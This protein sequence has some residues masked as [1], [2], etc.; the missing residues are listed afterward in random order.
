MM[1]LVTVCCPAKVLFFTLGTQTFVT[2][3]IIIIIIIIIIMVVGALDSVSKKLA[4]H[5]E[6][7]GIKNRTRTMQKSALLGSAHILRKVLEV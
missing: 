4:G 7:L 3:I 5:L 2:A 1:R 6:Q